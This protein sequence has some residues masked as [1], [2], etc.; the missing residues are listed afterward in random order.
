LREVT[1]TREEK[2]GLIG[3][4]KQ[5]CRD[6]K[7]RGQDSKKEVPVRVSTVGCGQKSTHELDKRKGI[8]KGKKGVPGPIGG[9]EKHQRKKSG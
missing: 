5:S 2:N 7:G 6:A 3:L 9:G 1:Y 4:A 8:N